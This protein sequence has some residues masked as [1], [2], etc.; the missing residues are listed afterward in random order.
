MYAITEIA[1]AVACPRGGLAALALALWRLF[2]T[3]R[4]APLVADPWNRQEHR[5]PTLDPRRELHHPQLAASYE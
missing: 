4:L 2:F 1:R 5:A 3:W